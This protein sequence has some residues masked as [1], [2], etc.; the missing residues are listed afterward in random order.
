[1]RALRGVAMSGLGY[2]FEDRDMAERGKVS[3]SLQKSLIKGY[4]IYILSA[5]HQDDRAHAKRHHLPYD[6]TSLSI[7][8]NCK[9]GPGHGHEPPF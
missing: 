1:M 8:I 2:I 7:E 5:F 3:Q 9:I 4:E 6:Q